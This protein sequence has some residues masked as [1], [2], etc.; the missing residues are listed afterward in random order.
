MA[1]VSL[2]ELQLFELGMLKD[3]KRV[4]EANNL[5]YYLYSG[6]CLGAVRHKG[7]IPWDDD[8]DIAMPYSD[9]LR[10]LQIAGPSLGE[11][12]FLQTTD[13]DDSFQ[14]GYARVRRNGTTMVRSWEVEEGHHGIWID[15][16]PLIGIGGKL[17]VKLKKTLIPLTNLLCTS[18]D[19]FT[20]GKGWLI[21]CNGK[22][23]VALIQVVRKLLGK[24]RKPLAKWIRRKLY[25]QT[26]KANLAEAWGSITAVVP[27]KAFVGPPSMLQ[28]EDDLFP[29]PPDYDCMLRYKY[30]NYMQLPPEEK[31]HSNH[32]DMI[33]DLEHDWETTKTLGLA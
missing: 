7:F 28:F 4:C 22:T 2:R 20:K 1:A 32:G 18:E 17:D 25:Q 29:V 31:R 16:F 8:I 30:G 6:T 23:K 11:R 10:F 14:F 5:C 19:A 21:Q 33:I 27:A 9:F 12:Y 13:T 24:R 26:G 3:I 15:I